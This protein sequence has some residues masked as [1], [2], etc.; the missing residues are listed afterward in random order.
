MAYYTNSILSENLDTSNENSTINTSV[1]QAAEETPNIKEKSNQNN[2]LTPKNI[3]YEN[4]LDSHEHKFNYKWPDPESTYP[5]HHFLLIYS[6]Q[7]GNTWNSI[8]HK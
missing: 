1:H 3:N 6:L 7:Y 2:D 4:I 5:H 8:N